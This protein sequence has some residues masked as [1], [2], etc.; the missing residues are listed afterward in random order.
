MCNLHY[1]PLYRHPFYKDKKI[2][3]LKNLMENSEQYY[4]S[5]LSLPIHPLLKKKQQLKIIY[6]IK[7]FLKK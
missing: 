4:K 3:N 7:K 5:A 2:R 1:I 6:L